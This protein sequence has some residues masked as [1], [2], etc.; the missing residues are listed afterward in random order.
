MT[1]VVGM[2][3]ETD[4]TI[5]IYMGADRYASNGFS[6]SLILN[7]K[8]FTLGG[9]M[10]IAISGAVRYSQ[11]LEHGFIPPEFEIGNTVENYLL[12]TFFPAFLETLTIHQCLFKENEQASNDGVFLLGF[13]GRLFKVQ[14]DFS[15]VEYQDKFISAGSGADFALGSLHATD[16]FDLAPELKIKL[17]V[18]ASATYCDSVAGEVNIKEMIF[19]KDKPEVSE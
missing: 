15:F 12:N 14:P 7:N 5:E 9:N 19:T 16:N 1:C 10:L 11:I 8:V 13:Q 2:I 4:D 18:D 6:G 3:V 17:A